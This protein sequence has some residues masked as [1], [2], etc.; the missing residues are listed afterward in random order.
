MKCL[1][2]GLRT[3]TF[4]SEIALHFSGLD[5][6]NKPIVWVFP[7]VLVCLDCGF[8]EF[9]IPDEQLKTL[10]NPIKQEA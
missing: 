9:A 1:S 6:L 3:Q 4:N 10:R 2:C 8:A 5:G 7:K